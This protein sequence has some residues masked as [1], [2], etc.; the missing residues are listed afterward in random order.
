MPG[1]SGVGIPVQSVNSW[2]VIHNNV[3]GVTSFNQNWLAY[4]NGFG[5]GL[6]SDN[7]WLGNELVYKLTSAATYSLRVEVGIALN[8]S[9]S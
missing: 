5:S 6:L 9:L 8:Q 7:F 4:K 1:N 3:A 2:I